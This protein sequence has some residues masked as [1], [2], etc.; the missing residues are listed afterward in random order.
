MK[1]LEKTFGSDASAMKKDVGLSHL[2]R[3][4]QVE[5]T[6]KA[7]E[8]VPKEPSISFDSHEYCSPAA[9]SS[10]TKRCR[11][12]PA[13]EDAERK[14]ELA[15]MARSS[16]GPMTSQAYERLVAK[17]RAARL[18]KI[19]SAGGIRSVL[20]SFKKADDPFVKAAVAP[21]HQYMADKDGIP[22]PAANSVPAEPELPSS[23]RDFTLPKTKVAESPAPQAFRPAADFD[24]PK[25][26]VAA[27]PAPQG[28]ESAA[29]K[30][31]PKS[32]ETV[33]PSPA[34]QGA[35]LLTDSAPSAYSAYAKLRSEEAAAAAADA[36]AKKAAAAKAEPA[37]GSSAWVRQEAAKQAAAA[38]AEGPARP[39]QG[40][41]E[42]AKATTGRQQA[43]ARAAIQRKAANV[44][45]NRNAAQTMAGGKRLRSS[46]AAAKAAAEGV[47]IIR[48]EAASRPQARPRAE[49]EKLVNAAKVN[50]RKAASTVASGAAAMGNLAR[51][52]AAEAEALAAANA[53]QVVDYI[54][55]AAVLVLAPLAVF[56]AAAVLEDAFLSPSQAVRAEG[57]SLAAHYLELTHA[58][59]RRMRRALSAARVAVTGHASDLPTSD[60]EGRGAIPRAVAASASALH[61]F[62]EAASSAVVQATGVQTPQIRRRQ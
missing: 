49:V 19:E 33:A 51:S 56:M 31:Q 44:A 7:V 57:T 43:M 42:A 15:K 41:E 25:G 16:F 50:A 23:A 11:P 12:N 36:D 13:E 32:T 58:L 17:K 3:M 47:T 55:V 39:P 60:N 54:V 29:A 8:E 53:W 40:A 22:L 9:L 4:L 46:A 30:P 24:L 48:D 61:A 6:A 1:G 5:E 28:A 14:E 20:D 34:P 37:L 10:P 62:A 35:E 18:S 59:W 45:G 27:S 21:V 2:E 26:A 38:K 52:K